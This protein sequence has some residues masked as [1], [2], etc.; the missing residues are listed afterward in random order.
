MELSKENLLG[1][2]L[3]LFPWLRKSINC[4]QYA[5]IVEERLLLPE[6]LLS[7]I[8]LS[9]LEEKK[10]TSQSAENVLFK[11]RQLKLSKEKP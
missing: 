5:L 8:K 1:V 10:A 2:F 3:S 9:W 11:L 7:L 6:E 4:L